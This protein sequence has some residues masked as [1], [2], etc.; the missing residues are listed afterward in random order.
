MEPFLR[1]GWSEINL[2]SLEANYRK[3][4]N[5]L[6]STTKVMAVLK[7]DGY[8][9]G[10]EDCARALDHFQE[11]WYGV[12]NLN[13]AL[14]VR[15]ASQKPILILTY[16]PPEYVEI[17][18]QQ[19]ITQTVVSLSYAQELADAAQAAG[20]VA[21]V[22]IK[23][24]TGMNRIGLLS[25]G[26]HWSTAVGEAEEILGNPWLRVTGIFTH[27]TTL[28]ELDPAS[29]KFAKEQ[30]NSYQRVVN[31]LME[32]GY[33]LGLRHACNSGGI[34]NMPELA[35]LD[36]V[37]TGNLLFGIYPESC[38]RQ[39]THFE[40]VLSFKS[41]VIHVKDVQAGQYFSYSMT[42]HADY[43]VKAATVSI[44]YAD[45][46]RRGLGNIGRVLIRGR[47]CQILGRVCM[48]QLIADVTGLD[49]V[50]VGDEVVLIGKQGAE[51]IE[52]GELSR[53]AQTGAPEITC[54]LTR[55]VQR[56]YIRNGKLA[57]QVDFERKEYPIIE[58]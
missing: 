56:R 38:M 4:K 57:Y 11:D 18:A 50:K 28:Y 1:R 9:C 33:Q 52:V 36:M 37:R 6:P 53:L 39:V 51:E 43:D 12:S 20:V 13:E 2:D 30:F 31:T 19:R 24:D 26:D 42:G 21:D 10:D 3:I 55:R 8:G 58:L 40:K 14:R 44:G 54:L 15:Q 46:F 32:K 23:L 35:Q 48:D 41:S 22:H 34:V 27:I 47:S 16:T 49:G 17:L 25:Y 7:A 29:V 5:L 45:G